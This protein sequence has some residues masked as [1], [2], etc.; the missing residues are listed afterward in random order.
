MAGD[1]VD[2]L[3]ASLVRRD[4]LDTIIENHRSGYQDCT[5]RLW[6]LVNLQIW[7]DLFLT[8]RRNR[9]SEVLTGTVAAGAL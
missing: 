3:V 7:G 5:D 8:G 2:G 4:V 1:A 9:H 6:R